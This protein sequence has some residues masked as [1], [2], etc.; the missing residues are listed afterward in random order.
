MDQQ[1]GKRHYLASLSKRTNPLSKTKSSEMQKNSGKREV[2][3]KKGAGPP[4][5]S[6]FPERAVLTWN[7]PK[8][9]TPL[10]MGNFI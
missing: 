5:G 2:G 4:A 8:L 9:I 10:L 3:R 6:F 7:S 1:L